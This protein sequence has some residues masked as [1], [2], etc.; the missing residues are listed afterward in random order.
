MRHVCFSNMPIETTHIPIYIDTVSMP[1]KRQNFEYYQNDKQTIVVEYNEDIGKIKQKKNSFF[2]IYLFLYL[3]IFLRFLQM[4]EVIL[5]VMD[6]QLNVFNYIIPKHYES[7]MIKNILN[8]ILK[9]YLKI[10]EFF[11]LKLIH[12][13]HLFIFIVMMVNISHH[14]IFNEEIFI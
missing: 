5:N 9:T 10:K 12:L 3:K 2:K 14:L 11:I 8:L 4:F 1:Y 7:N 13:V 6:Y